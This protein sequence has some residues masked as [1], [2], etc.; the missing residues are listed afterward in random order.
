MTESFHL[1]KCEGLIF[2]YLLFSRES[3]QALTYV[4]HLTYLLPFLQA[5]NAIF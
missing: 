2:H 3:K 5:V 1:F 4:V